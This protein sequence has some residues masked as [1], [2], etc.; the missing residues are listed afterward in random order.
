MSSFAPLSSLIE[1]DPVSLM[2]AVDRILTMAGGVGAAKFLRGLI[3]VHD[4]SL[5][6]AVVNVA[7]DFV[8]H[9]LRISPDIDTVTYT[10]SDRINPETGWGRDGESWAVMGELEVL[11]G[12]TWF[13]L[14]DKDLALHLYRTQ[15]LSEGANLSTVT[16]EVTTAFGITATVLPASNDELA[17]KLTLTDGTEIDFQDYFVAR[18]HDVAIASVRFDGADA[19]QPSDGVIQQ[20]AE[21]GLIVIAPSNPIVSIGPL[22]SIKGIKQGLEQRRDDVVAVSPIV[23]GKALKGPAERLL[24]ELGH[25]PSVVGI[26]TIYRDIAATLVIDSIDEAHV[27][28]VEAT[29]VRCFV[30]DTIM[31][32]VTKSAALA[33]SILEAM[34]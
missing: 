2:N 9:G 16:A 15:R 10:L 14:G 26:A 22:L 19:A 13:G 34:R 24:R 1:S 3:E 21:A 6:T 4:P 7:D 20:I 12:H 30:T 17:T 23:G 11:G 8:L 32:D 27:A 5:C 28:A 18:R 33:R 29:G 25:E 31:S